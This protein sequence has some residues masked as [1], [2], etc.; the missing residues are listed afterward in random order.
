MQVS[1]WR[2]LIDFAVLCNTNLALYSG[3]GRP[4]MACRAILVQPGLLQVHVLVDSGASGY[5]ATA[6]WPMLASC[7]CK[8][9]CK[10]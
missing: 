8:P 9:G 4:C 1:F 10:L 7:L 2:G 6:A 3:D 5:G